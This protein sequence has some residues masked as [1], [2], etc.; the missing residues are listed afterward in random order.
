M[1]WGNKKDDHK[2]ASLDISIQDMSNDELI[3]YLNEL[4]ESCRICI[5]KNQ[6]N[7]LS[8]YS[9]IKLRVKTLL[10]NKIKNQFNNL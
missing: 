3:K 2:L 6:Y 10:E 1:W 9:D 7:S 4:D 8:V 5:R